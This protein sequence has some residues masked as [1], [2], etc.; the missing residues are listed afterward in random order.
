MKLSFIAVSAFVLLS[1]QAYSNTLSIQYGN[2]QC[3]LSPS[4]KEDNPSLNLYAEHE[5][6]EGVK[7]GVQYQIPIT[8]LFKKRVKAETPVNQ[9]CDKIYAL[10]E[11]RARLDIEKQQLEIAEIRERMKKN[12]EAGSTSSVS[13]QADDW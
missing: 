1:S 6:K 12:A 4:S 2:L 5:A 8:S 3:G 10:I 7:L 9:S 11:E 13:A